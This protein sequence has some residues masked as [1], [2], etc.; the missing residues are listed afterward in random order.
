NPELLDWLACELVDSDW[1]LKHI[2]RLL[3]TSATYRQSSRPRAEALAR[4]ARGALLWRFPPRRMEAEAI[5]DN[6]LLVSGSLDVRMEGPGFLMFHPNDNYSR[7]WIPK[8]EFGRSE[9]RRMVYALKLRMEQDAVFGSFDCP[10]AGQVAP[11]RNQSTTPIQSL[12]LFNS[13]FVLDQSQRFAARVEREVGDD[14]ALHVERVWLL[15]FGRSPD[16]D[17]LTAAVDLVNR[18]GLHALCRAVF[19][20]NEFLFLR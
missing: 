18:H 12:A 10:D 1:S 8:D 15:A 11:R 14:A 9:F 3:L 17:E 2:H 20:A 6:V 7:N 4:D 5:R 19:N 16:A 13:D